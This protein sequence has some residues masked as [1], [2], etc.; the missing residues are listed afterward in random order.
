MWWLHSKNLHCFIEKSYLE[1]PNCM[2]WLL[3]W[4][5]SKCQS[6]G[7]GFASF[8][9]TIL[10]GCSHFVFSST[11]RNREQS[12]TSVELHWVYTLVRQGK[13]IRTF[14][15]LLPPEILQTLTKSCSLHLQI[16]DG[17][18]TVTPAVLSDAVVH[19]TCCILFVGKLKCYKFKWVAQGHTMEKWQ[20]LLGA[21]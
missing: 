21:E 14:R 8:L 11:C 4:S 20:S 9:C 16:K 10:Q 3:V 19:S 6:D 13:I 17:D 18:I 15:A 7:V 2:Q 1:T 5:L 12:L